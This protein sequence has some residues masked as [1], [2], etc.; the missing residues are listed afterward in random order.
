VKLLHNEG[1]QLKEVTAEAGLAKTAGWWNRLE[2]ADVNAD[3]YPD[4]V[5]G[6][7]GLNSRFKATEQKPVTMYAHDFDGNSS[8]EQ[9]VTCYNGEKAF[10]M[11]LRHDLVNVLPY[12]KKKYLKYDDY[13]LQTVEDMFTPAQLKNAIKLEAFELRSCVFVN[14]KKGGFE[15]QA[16]PTEAQFAPLYAITVT[17]V[18]EDGKMDIVAGGNLYESKP[19]V[20]IYA[21]SHGLLLKGDGNGNFTALP[22]AKCG[23]RTEGAV[24]DIVLLKKGK[25]DLLLV[26]KNNAPI[27]TWQKNESNHKP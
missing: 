8:V 16:L 25:S 24:R 15:K 12:L 26:A 22:P 21:G 14:N 2:V 13:K 27:E 7:H 19:E 3:G 9:I 18:D 10:P 23:F 1:G 11:A 5:A 6:N 20:G 17:D 4:L